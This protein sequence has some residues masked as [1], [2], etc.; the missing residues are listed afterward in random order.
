MLTRA[1]CDAY[2]ARLDTMIQFYSLRKTTG[3]S[4]KKFAKLIGVRHRDVQRAEEAAF[5]GLTGEVL[6]RY[7]TALNRTITVAYL[8]GAISPVSP[9]ALPRP[10]NS[11]RMC[12]QT[13]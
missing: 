9:S 7:S 11:W 5:D 12:V 10:R 3:L 6:Q 13:D 1:E 2:A 8:R 4:Q